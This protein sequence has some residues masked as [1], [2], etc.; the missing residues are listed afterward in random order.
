VTLCPGLITETSHRGTS[1]GLR[2][3]GGDQAS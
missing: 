1:S 3:G 2:V